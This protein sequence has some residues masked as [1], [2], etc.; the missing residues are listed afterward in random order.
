MS[1]LLGVPAG[2]PGSGRARYARAMTLWREGCLS[3]A[4]LEAY[5]S[6]AACDSEPP[7]A[8]F[9]RRGLAL[10]AD[11]PPTP[12]EA[13]RALADEVD[14]Y[15]AERD[16][17]GIA[18]VRTGLARWRGGPVTPGAHANPV[19]R[20]C[21]PDALRA[22]DAGDPALAGAI[23]CAA[24]LLRW[25]SYDCYAP[26][27]IGAQFP[28]A[29]AFASLI[30]ADAAIPAQD[31]DLG[32]FLIAPHV[33]YRDHCHRAPELYVPLTGPHGW[34]F[35]ADRPLVMKP[36][37]QPVWNPPMQPHLIKAGPL[38]FLCLYA[39]TQD[40][41]ALAEVVPATDWDALEALRLG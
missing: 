24:P 39:W 8:E 32:L 29:H 1:G 21:L 38:P 17:H 15:L 12:E 41:A 35:G 4:Q 26:G 27:T 25:Q 14:R 36:A 28:P 18:E 31:F 11:P 9:R 40:V 20:A 2:M 6:A 7:A 10:P 13:I 5:R 3:D 33:L 37:H 22:L 19:V 30:G 34:R 23:A 16:G